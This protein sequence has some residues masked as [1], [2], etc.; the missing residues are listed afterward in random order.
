MSNSNDY[1]YSLDWIVRRL[2]K[3]LDQYTNKSRAA[4]L[5]LHKNRLIRVRRFILLHRKELEAHE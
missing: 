2:N 1:L 4:V 3:N 5:R